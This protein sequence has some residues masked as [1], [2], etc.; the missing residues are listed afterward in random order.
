MYLTLDLYKCIG[1]WKSVMMYTINDNF[2]CEEIKQERTGKVELLMKLSYK[3]LQEMNYR[4]Y[5]LKDAP[6]RIL[7]FG[8][9]NFLRAFADYYFD[10]MN[11]KV[12][13]H[14]KTVICQ[15]VEEGIA[16]MINEQEGLYTLY[17][18][19]YENGVKINQKRLISC[20]SRC[21]NPYREYEE[22]MA[23][24]KNPDLRFV[25]SNTTEAGITY[26]PK[27]RL[28]EQPPSSYPAKLT[29]L[30]YERFR[31]FGNEKGKGFIVL[32]CELIDDNGKE[33][34]RCILEYARQW[35]LEH[36]FIS[37]LEKENIFCSTLADRIVTGYPCAEA[38]R[39]ND[40]NGY[41]DQLIDTGEVFGFWVIEGP[42]VLKE[43]LPFEAAGLPVLITDD[44]KPYK[45][46]MVRILNGAHTGVALGAYLAGRNTVRECME[47]EVIKGFVDRAVYQ[48]IIPTL[49]LPENE[50]KDFAASV[51]ER[52]MNPYID[53]RLLAISWNSTSKWRARVL[54]GLKGFLEKFGVLPKCITASLAFYIAFYSAGV[55]EP[56]G[57]Y[58][59]RGEDRYHI[60]DDPFVLSFFGSFKGRGDAYIVKSVLGN[61]TFWDE[62]LTA[63]PGLETETLRLLRSIRKKGAYAVMK[64]CIL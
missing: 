6:E 53:H 12:G 50:L 59:L 62:D 11:E 29:Q 15:P 28:N 25:I 17:L 4:R 26:D 7:Q 23:C 40:E 3:T 60:S 52:F 2:T 64:E 45:Q 27:C 44:Y 37:W 51:A 46:R 35:D 24:A 36:S 5:L 16:D 14:S 33:L 49:S 32:A 30:L 9:G 56:D 34:K 55:R 43:E 63:V 20:I 1:K 38:G 57:M 22:Y 31:I 54:P 10:V 41:A 58:G 42:R 8:E 13:F 18:R 61:K 19:G 21:L 48:E 39:I 47:D